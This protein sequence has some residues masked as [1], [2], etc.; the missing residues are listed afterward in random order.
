MKRGDLSCIKNKDI[1]HNFKHK[2]KTANFSNVKC[3]GI[4]FFYI[5]YN[6]F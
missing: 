4:I 1:L 3:V 5:M 6:K 2:Y